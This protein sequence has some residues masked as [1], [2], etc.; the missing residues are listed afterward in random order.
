MVKC[1]RPVRIGVIVCCS[2]LL[3][4]RRDQIFIATPLKVN[5]GSSGAECK[6]CPHT[7]R[8]A[9]ARSL[10]RAGDYKHLVPPGPKQC[11]SNTLLPQYRPLELVYN[12]SR[13]MSSNLTE[14]A[15]KLA[16]RSESHWLKRS[17]PVLPRTAGVLNSRRLRN[18]SLIVVSNL[19]GL[20][21]HEAG[22]GN[23]LKKTSL[24]SSVQ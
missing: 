15:K 22:R 19:F 10:G 1:S 12:H 16:S 14:E 7:L 11:L 24:P 13:A 17:G 4:S 2:T 18:E 9:G 23:R 5:Y 20:I 21:P 3:G 8:S 6:D